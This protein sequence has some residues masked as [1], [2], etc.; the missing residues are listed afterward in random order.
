MRR[1]WALWAFLV[2]GC[3]CG[4][5]GLV[6]A[7]PDIFAEPSPL[8]FGAVYPGL[9]A[10]KE[11]TV[12]NRGGAVLQISSV[13][14]KEPGPGAAG[15]DNGWDTPSRRPRPSRTPA[16]RDRKGCIPAA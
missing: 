9:T 14:V 7:T 6:R 12:Q 10:G 15:T 1:G 5:S 13:R 8:A 3:D 16:M 4:G 11:L 2:A